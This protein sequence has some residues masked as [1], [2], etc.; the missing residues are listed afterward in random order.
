MPQRTADCALAGALQRSTSVTAAT[1]TNPPARTRT[2]IA[3]PERRPRPGDALPPR[4]ADW[5]H[6]SGAGRATRGGCRTDE[7]RQAMAG[8]RETVFTLEAT[9]VKFGR[10]AAADAGWELVRLRVK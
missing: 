5:H 4:R 6:A 1:T 9:P 2:S 3:A 10:G 7:G 8:D